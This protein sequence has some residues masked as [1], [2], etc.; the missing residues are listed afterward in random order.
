MLIVPLL[1]WFYVRETQT[2]DWLVVYI[3]LGIV[4]FTSL[5]RLLEGKLHK[6]NPTEFLALYPFHILLILIAGAMWSTLSYYTSVMSGVGSSVGIMLIFAINGLI[7]GTLFVLAPTGLWQS[8]YFL[9]LGLPT[10]AGIAQSENSDFA[11]VVGALFLIYLSH[12]LITGY[13][14]FKNLKL[15][16]KNEVDLY[17]ESEK[18]NSF[19]E[20]VPGFIA[21]ADS[22]GKWLQENSK[23]SE[24]KEN[25]QFQSL[26]AGFNA[27]GSKHLSQ[28]VSWSTATGDESYLVGIRSIQQNNLTLLVIVGISTTEL[29]QAK[30]EIALQ[31]TKA[32]FASRLAT[33]GEMASGIAH[34]INNPLAVIVG[35]ASN[36]IRATEKGPQ[37]SNERLIERLDKIVKTSHRISKIIQGLKAFARQGDKDLFTET[38]VPQLIEETLELCR[39]K[40]YR[41]SVNLI[42]EQV[43][44]VV[45]PMR[46]VQI[47]Q[48]LVNLLNNA[49]DAVKNLEMRQISIHFKKTDLGFSIFVTDSGGGVSEQLKKKIFEPFF[50]TKEVGEGTGL[51]LSIS[52][53]IME[54]HHG[55]LLL[56]EQ[57]QQ[58][59][60]EIRLPL[61]Q[62][63]TDEISSKKSAA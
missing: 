50:T 11:H 61:K 26:L 16:Y 30:E 63:N 62:P 46:S 2:E 34:E 28:E 49:F 1:I 39:E 8:L 14:A 47:S 56:H 42:V 33:L 25:S 32:E 44:M 45:L 18:N 57:S 35:N 41:N 19:M 59:T 43:P 38:P 21:I 7:S 36:L 60:F 27:S 10:I 17:L 48:V 31:K 55:E 53:G 52:K 51:G 15:N 20:V 12:H 4:F 37:L 5:I 23:F 22:H 40:F 9:I 29:N 54:D 24:V 13:Q 3:C 58:T 6:N